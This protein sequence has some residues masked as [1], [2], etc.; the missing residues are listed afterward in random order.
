MTITFFIR[1]PETSAENLEVAQLERPYGDKPSLLQPS[2][3]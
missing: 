3:M 2:S 1:Q